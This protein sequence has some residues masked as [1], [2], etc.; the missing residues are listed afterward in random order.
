LTADAAIIME[1]TLNIVWLAIAVGALTAVALR[2]REPL[3]A[4]AVVC[5]IALLFPIISIT[6]DLRC[7][8]VFAEASMKR[9][10][11]DGD[12]QHGVI[13][14]TSLGVMALP[15]VDFTPAFAGVAA[16]D[17]LICNRNTGRISVP[18]RAPPQRNG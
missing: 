15:A 7:D 3:I 2:R 13:S 11:S 10:G 8:V 18:A 12:H 16:T 17:C 9:R 1:L 4:T 6:D 14:L 5:G